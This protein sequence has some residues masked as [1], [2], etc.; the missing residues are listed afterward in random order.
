MDDESAAELVGANVQ[1]EGAERVLFAR[2][3][4]VGDKAT[5]YIITTPEKN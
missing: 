5:I 2:D 4:T 1:R 3:P